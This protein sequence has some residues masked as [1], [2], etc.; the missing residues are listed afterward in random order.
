MLVVGPRRGK[1]FEPFADVFDEAALK[2]IDVDGRGDVHGRDKAQAVPDAAA[3]DDLLHVVGDV[4][5]LARTARFKD[6]V[7]GVTFHD[8]SLDRPEGEFVAILS[9]LS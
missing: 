7:F 9:P 3:R 8:R 5:H 6:Q 1:L 2:V 4:H